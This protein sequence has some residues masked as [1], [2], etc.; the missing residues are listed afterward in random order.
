M[1]NELLLTE[2]AS[3]GIYKLYLLLL[4]FFDFILVI[5][6][7]KYFDSTYL[8]FGFASNI[9]FFFSSCFFWLEAR[10]YSRLIYTL[11]F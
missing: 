8:I 6:F 2:W 7:R 5:Y 1:K 9:D 3:C 11:S 10:I 4:L